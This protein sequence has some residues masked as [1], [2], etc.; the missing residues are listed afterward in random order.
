MQGQRELRSVGLGLGL[1]ALPLVWLALLRICLDLPCFSS[2]LIGFGLIS[3]GFALISTGFRL[4][5][6]WI[7]NFRS[8]S[9]RFLSI[10][11][12]GGPRGS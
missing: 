4:D 9:L 6:A 1:A 3:H 2:I 10:L 8:L 12:L 11:A 5:L 7:L